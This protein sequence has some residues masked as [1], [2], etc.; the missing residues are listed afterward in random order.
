MNYR[1]LSNRRVT[2]S[3]MIR[4]RFSVRVSVIG[5]PIARFIIDRNMCIHKYNLTLL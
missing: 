3:I 4:F 2:F 5:E 1:T